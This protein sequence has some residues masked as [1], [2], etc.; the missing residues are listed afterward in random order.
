MIYQVTWMMELK[1]REIASLMRRKAR[2]EKIEESCRK[3]CS[4]WT[5]RLKLRMGGMY[6]VRGKAEKATANASCSIIGERESA[7]NNDE[8]TMD[9]ECIYIANKIISTET[10]LK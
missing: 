1:M 3:I 5:K 10:K 8:S 7:R 2:K 9:D 4:V 6:K